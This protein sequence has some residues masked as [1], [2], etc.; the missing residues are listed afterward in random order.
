MLAM[1]TMIFSLFAAILIN[2]KFKG[3][4]LARMVFFLPIILGLDIMRTMMSSSIEGN[5]VDASVEPIFT[6]EDGIMAFLLQNSLFGLYFCS[7]NNHPFL[8][9][10]F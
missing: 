1:L 5:F 6:G 8:I 9:S 2:K 7:L 10:P 3:R 4:A